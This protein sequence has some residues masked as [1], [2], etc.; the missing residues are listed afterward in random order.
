MRQCLA[1]LSEFGIPIACITNKPIRFTT[2]L[3]EFLELDGFFGLVVGGDSLAEKKP[4]PAPL[5]Y[6]ANFFKV[7][8]QNCL[9]V[10]DSINDIRAARAASMPVLAVPYGY[11]HGEDIR[12]QRPDMILESLAELPELFGSKQAL[13][14][15]ENDYRSS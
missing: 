11:Y 14:N 15:D 6:A 12:Q 4:S 2:P 8:P 13:V 3:L 5:H 1:A 10:G 9:M 7:S